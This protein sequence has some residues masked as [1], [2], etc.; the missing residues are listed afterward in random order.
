MESEP[1]PQTADDDLSIIPPF[2]IDTR[3]AHGNGT[4]FVRR[5]GTANIIQLF[6]SLDCDRASKG[7]AFSID[8]RSK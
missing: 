4:G 7:I 6:I 5:S 1:A 3:I 2:G 8:S